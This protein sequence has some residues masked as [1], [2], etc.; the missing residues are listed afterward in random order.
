[1]DLLK[2]SGSLTLE[3]TKVGSRTSEKRLPERHAVCTSE[4]SNEAVSI[5][6]VKDDCGTSSEECVAQNK[7]RVVSQD[8]KQNCFR[9]PKN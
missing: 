4:E 7:V 8:V 2:I 3:A 6:D 9:E 1:M 5:L